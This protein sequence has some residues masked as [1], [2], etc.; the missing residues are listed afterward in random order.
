M[1]DYSQ[2]KTGQQ[3]EPTTNRRC[4]L[5][6]RIFGNSLTTPFFRPAILHSHDFPLSGKILGFIFGNTK[7]QVM[8]EPN[9]DGQQE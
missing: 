1:K 6:P 7:I 2:H 5:S 4:P 9:T 3:S 8:P